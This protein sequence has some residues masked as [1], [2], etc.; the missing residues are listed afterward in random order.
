[1]RY[2]AKVNPF[3]ALVIFFR[4]LFK[5]A[6][7]SYGA[8]Y[9]LFLAKIMRHDYR[10]LPKAFIYAGLGHHFFMMTEDILNSGRAGKSGSNP[11][12]KERE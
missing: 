4:V 8:D 1:V 12:V 3:R 2:S 11:V 6:F 7:S 9:L 10:Y 5:Q